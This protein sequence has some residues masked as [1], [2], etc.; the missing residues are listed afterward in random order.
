MRE[1]FTINCPLPYNHPHMGEV[2]SIS[3]ISSFIKKLK[4]A[5]KS[6]VLVGGCF[7]VLHPGHI[8]FLQK[9][10]KWGD[11]LVVL[12]E[13]DQRVQDLK[14]VSRPVHNQKQRAL[15]LSALRFVDV[16]IM[17][18]FMDKEAQYLRVI[19]RA[20][21]DIVAV[22]SGD[23]SNIHKKRVAKKVGAKLKY[24]TRMIG[25]HSTSRILQGKLRS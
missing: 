9:A 10:K 25:N 12:L 8:I 7:D 23:P 3:K 24:V 6:I 20:K 11:I 2:V 4:K 21:P 14:G 17:L 22:T 13:N 1:Y 15:V 19:G 5:G 16:V 18:P